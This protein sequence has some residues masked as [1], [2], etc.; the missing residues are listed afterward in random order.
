MQTVSKCINWCKSCIARLRIFFIC[1]DVKFYQIFLSIFFF[2]I[3][4]FKAIKFITLQ[5][6]MIFSIINTIEFY[7]IKNHV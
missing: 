2:A 5:F 7:K 3:I 1:D 4:Q 6:K